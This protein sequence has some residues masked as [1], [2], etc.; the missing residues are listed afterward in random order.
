[1]VRIVLEKAENGVVKLVE[2]TNAN[3]AGEIYESKS[4]YELDNDSNDNYSRTTCLLN[5]ILNDLGIDTGNKFSKNV[6][7]METDWGSHYIPKEDEI[8]QRIRDL[9]VEIKILKDLIKGD[10][11]I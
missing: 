3:G 10:G 1:M 8:L 11:N 6:L 2:D 7:V 9:K 5:D 4:V